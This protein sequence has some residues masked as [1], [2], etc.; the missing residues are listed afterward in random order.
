MGVA[1]TGSWR[2]SCLNW[3]TSTESEQPGNY[4]TAQNLFHGKKTN[5]YHWFSASLHSGKERPV[6]KHTRDSHH[7]T[8]FTL[9]SLRWNSSVAL[10]CNQLSSFSKLNAI[11]SQSQTKTHCL[12]DS[13]YV[14]AICHFC[15]Y[16]NSSF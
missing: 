14:K 4:T 13:I 2:C 15:S 11:G 9:L 3:P 8:R 12:K 16:S 5:S 1:Q 7:W 6:L 10:L